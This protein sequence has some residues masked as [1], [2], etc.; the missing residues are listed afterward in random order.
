M[1]EAD[2]IDLL[3]EKTN[4]GS[5]KKEGRTLRHGRTARDVHIVQALR[6]GGAR[7][8]RDGSARVDMAV[9]MVLRVVHIDT[10]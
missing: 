5:A 3:I 7:W 2:R 6:Y 8:G 10:W 9:C 4:I 1:E